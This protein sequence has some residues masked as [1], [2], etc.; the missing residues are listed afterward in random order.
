MR[1]IFHL[2]TLSKKLTMNCNRNQV[3]II[4][5]KLTNSEK[6]TMRFF[7]TGVNGQLGHDVMLELSRRG[8]SAVG[9]GSGEACRGTDAVAAMPYARLDITDAGAVSRLLGELRPDAV[10]HCSAWTAVDA[11]EEPENRGRVFALNADGPAHIAAACAEMGA[12]M[13]YLSTDYIFDG[14]G[15]LPWRADDERYAPLNVYGQSKLEGELAV[16]RALS[17]AFVV[18]TAWVFGANG[19]NFVKTML[20]VGRTHGAVRVVADQIGTPTYTRD[21]ARLLVDMSETEK[22]GV[23]HATNEG[24]FISWYDFTR[25]IYR[26]AGIDTEV[27]PVTTAE[28]GLS[29]AVRPFNSRL[30][31]S[32]LR[33]AGFTPLPDWRDA[34]RR[35]LTEIGEIKNGT[36]QSDV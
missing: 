15:S 12:K 35:Y 2:F 23:Y 28:Y 29:R 34:L 16:R 32:K 24:G 19:K 4:P 17:E 6:H 9:S 25:E 31:K 36:D 10:I 18:R 33:E 20:N 7:V 27:I 13:L 3:R 22:Y 30:D 1:V 14:Q 5:N 26:Q 8:Y 11:A 21:L